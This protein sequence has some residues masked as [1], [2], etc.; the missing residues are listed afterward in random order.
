MTGVQTCALPIY[1]VLDH[2]R[3]SRRRAVMFSPGEDVDKD[4]AD[5]KAWSAGGL[6]QRLSLEDALHTLPDDQ[7]AVVVLLFVDGLT[8]G[9][10]AAKLGI[11]ENTVKSRALRG[12]DNLRAYLEDAE[13]IETLLERSGL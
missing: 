3:A 11:P 5:T 9:E 4:F 6:E 10:V 8:S 7:R 2:Q 13:D 12:R 1:K